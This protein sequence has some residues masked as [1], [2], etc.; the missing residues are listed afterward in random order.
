VTDAVSKFPKSKADGTSTS[1]RID[2]GLTTGPGAGL[3]VNDKL[4]ITM[5]IRNNPGLVN[6]GSIPLVNGG[7]IKTNSTNLLFGIA[8]K[9]GAGKIE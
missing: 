3:P 5:E 1:K 9:L 4:F 8:Y 2:S 6:T 7:T